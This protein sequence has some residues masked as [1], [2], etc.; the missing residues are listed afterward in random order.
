MQLFKFE[1]PFSI[2]KT[3]INDICIKTDKYY[4]FTYLQYKKEEYNN[5]ISQ[6]C[7][8]LTNYYREAKLF[9]VKRVQ[10]FNSFNTV[11]RQL[12]KLHN[13]PFSI[14]VK[15]NQG[16]SYSQYKIYLEDDVVND[17]SSN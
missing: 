6:I 15:Y 8:M 3:I 14:S 2:V 4:L 9:Y 5:N 17:I 12:C 11:L 13:I 1:L 16:R 7:D 10:T